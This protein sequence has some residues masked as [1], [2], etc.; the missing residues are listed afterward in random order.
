VALAKARVA[1]A[2]QDGAPEAPALALVASPPDEP[3]AEVQAQTAAAARTWETLA[4]SGREVRFSENPG[5][6]VGV[7]LHHQSGERIAVLQLNDLYTL[8]EQEGA[9]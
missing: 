2:A 9:G 3:P 7:S 1:R 4:A 5:G 8:I 6:R